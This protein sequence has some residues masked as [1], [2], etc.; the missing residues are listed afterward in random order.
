M[1]DLLEGAYQYEVKIM[2]QE[3]IYKDHCFTL[4]VFN[5]RLTTAELGYMEAKDRPTPI[6]SKNL[7]SP[8]HTLSQAGIYLLHCVYFI[9]H[10]MCL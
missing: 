4:D 6:D 7:T 5:S 10:I 8:G 9:T 2:L 3:M 1:H